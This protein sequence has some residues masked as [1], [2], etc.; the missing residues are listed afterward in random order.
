MNDELEHE[1][2]LDAMSKAELKAEARSRGLPTTGTK[3]ALL[4]R[5]EAH[6]RDDS[7]GDGGGQAAAPAAEERGGAEESGGDGSRDSGA[8]EPSATE[9]EGGGQ[10]DRGPQEEDREAPDEGEA[11]ADQEGAQAE[12]DEGEPEAREEDE[13]EEPEAREEDEPEEPEAREEEPEARDDGE[14]APE[15]QG[16]AQR[17]PR[18]QAPTAGGGGDGARPGLADVATTAARALT[19]LTGRTV[20]AVSGVR[21]NNDGY[22]VTIEVLEL[23]RVPSTTDVLATYEVDV[24]SD[25]SIVEYSRQHRY[26]RNQTSRE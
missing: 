11:E 4:E 17:G 8:G 22:Q 24:A 16:D 9:A 7:E 14:S 23:S 18:E 2:G 1:T 20:D 15:R 10:E 19:E 5:V 26:Y 13:P 6:D 21:R 25:G 3:A 12:A